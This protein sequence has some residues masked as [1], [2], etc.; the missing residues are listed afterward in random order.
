MIQH[1]DELD[2]EVSPDKTQ[3][4]FLAFGIVVDRL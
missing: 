3:V 1:A 4:H 2:Q